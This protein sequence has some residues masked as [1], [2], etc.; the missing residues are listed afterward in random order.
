[1]SEKIPTNAQLAKNIKQINMEKYDVFLSRELVELDFGE[2]F[3]DVVSTWKF[4]IQISIDL[5]KIL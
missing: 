3:F 2:E 5:K 4:L 1:M